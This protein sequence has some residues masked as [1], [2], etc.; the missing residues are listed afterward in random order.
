VTTPPLYVVRPFAVTHGEVF[1]LAAPMTLAYL[2]VPLIG[3]IDTAVIGQLGDAALLGG[4]AVGA[5]VLDVVFVTF[6]FLR[7]GTTGLTAQALGADD[8]AET[9]GVLARALLVAILSGLAIV[10][11]QKPFVEAG[12]ALM[13]PGAP[14]AS[15]MR[16][17]LYVR[18]WAT[19]FGLVNYVLL[20]WLLGLG[21]SVI[22]LAVQTLFA[23]L[24]IALSVWFVLGLGYG[25]AGVAW[26]SVLAEI[27]TV[28]VQVPLVVRLAPLAARPSWS[29]ILERTGFMRLL[30]INRDIMIR[31]FSLLFAFAFF[32]RQGAQF[33]PVVLAANAILM[34]FF[35]VGGYFLDGMAN[36]A[37][38]LAGRAVGAR[39]RPA[40]ERTVWLTTIWGMATALA[41]TF[42]YALFGPLI[43]DLM[44]T[45]PEV[46]ETA[47]HYLVWA[48]LTPLAG[49][50]AFQMDGIFIGA[51]WSRD[52]RNMMLLSVLIYLA[53]WACL[54]PLFGNHGLWMALL[55]FLGARSFSFHWRMR[56]LLPRTFPTAT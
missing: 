14:V 17:Y 46:R 24:N 19:P 9:V 39:F 34:H 42:V 29:R 1:R 27:V 38:Q 5:I 44:T 49:V 45:A 6:N 51:T 3:V 31:S 35:L 18:V 16:D 11:L 2:S 21:R 26:G 54:T 22:V 50:V 23:L 15:P 28:L 25:V 20:G 48:V 7:S 53:A 56:Q 40:F 52:M 30:A 41:L 32:T 33:G 12:V 55:V 13:D 36:A 47:R 43:V 8:R 37:E 10:V 4:I